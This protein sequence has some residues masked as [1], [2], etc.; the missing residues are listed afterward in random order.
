MI[1][2]D[3]EHITDWLLEKDNP[4]VRYFTLKD[5]L[6]KTEN[7][8]EVLQAK[9][10]ILKSETVIKILTGRSEEGYWNH[11]KKYMTRYTG[12]FWRFLFLLE[13]G[14][15]PRNPLIQKTADYLLKTAYSFERHMFVN[16]K[17]SD[18]AICYTGYL[19][20]AMLKC[21]LYNTPEVQDCL[22][23]FIGRIQFS[24]GDA[25]VE[26]PEDGCM[27]KHTCIRLTIPVL[28][29]LQE[30]KT[31]DNAV[32]VGKILLEG[33]EFLLK[34]HLY[35]RSHDLTKVMNPRLTKLTFPNF[36]YIDFLQMLELLLDM[37]C[38]DERMEDAYQALLKKS[39]KDDGKW[40]LERLCNE[41][42][43]NDLF[44]IPVT[45][46]ERSMESKWITMKSL[47]VIKNYQG[48]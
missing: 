13:L 2:K 44:P 24:D 43:K 1:Y 42:G 18:M 26:N 34:H 21:G 12:T 20:W 30:L 40:K 32:P 39:S 15:D 31:V 11:P 48:A 6:N 8:S 28:R 41:R 16:E 25:E 36:Y 27:G 33:Q 19:L 46:E 45:L 7:D 14:V 37:G 5:I 47:K 29:A 10:D 35:K 17:E 22:Q 23:G 9:K 38:R 3:T 4:S